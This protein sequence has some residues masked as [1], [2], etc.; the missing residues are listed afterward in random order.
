MPDETEPLLSKA[1]SYETKLMI[2]SV[3]INLNTMDMEEL[4]SGRASSPVLEADN[5][6]KIQLHVSSRVM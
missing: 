3:T 6:F 2:D 5:I 4:D 1:S